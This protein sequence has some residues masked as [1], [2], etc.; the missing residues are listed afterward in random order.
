MAEAAIV[1]RD[2][3]SEAASK[4]DVALKELSKAVLKREQL[5]AVVAGLERSISERKGDDSSASGDPLI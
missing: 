3:A 2:T 1:D 4:A 5:V